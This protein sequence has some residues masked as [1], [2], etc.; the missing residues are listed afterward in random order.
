MISD[1]LIHLPTSKEPDAGVDYG[2]SVGSAFKAHVTG[3]AFALEPL[4]APMY[5]GAVPGEIFA[6]FR[7]DAEQAAAEAAAR[8]QKAAEGAGCTADTRLVTTTIDGAADA[9]GRLARVYDLTVLTQPN[10]DK[11]GPEAALLE[12]VLFESGRSV[13][14]VPYVQKKPIEFDRVLI[15]WDGGR[16]AARAVAEAGPFLAK[17]KEVQILVVE[18]GKPDLKAVPGADLARHLARHNLK[19][20]LRRAVVSGDADID[21]TILNEISDSDV[22]LVVMGGYGHT[23]LREF[24][25]GGVTRGIIGSMTAPVLMAH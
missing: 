13:L 7:R 21:A 22:D 19:V 12:A 6:D 5:F 10:P 11:P 23:R 18:S 2:L 8:F 4:V 17:A 3:L 16:P 25:L 1:I 14:V 15:A 24:V 9:I 20:E